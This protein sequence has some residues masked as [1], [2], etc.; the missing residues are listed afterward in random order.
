MIPERVE[1]VRARLP[2]VRPFVAA[3][4]TEH[5]RDV[6]LVRVLAGGHEGWGECGALARPTYTGEYTDGA[7]AVLRDELA[8]AAVAGRDAGVVGHPMA[9][10]AL[11][12]AIDDARLRARGENLAASLGATRERVP[13]GVVAGVAD[14]V[15]ALL[16]EVAGLVA[17]GYVRVKLKVRPGWDVEP[18]AAVR[19][20]WPELALAVDANG[21]Y[22]GRADDVAALERFGLEYVEQPLAADDLVGSAALADR[23]G[24]PIALDESVTSAGLAAAALR[25]GAC[26]VVSIKAAR[27]GG[28]D[29]AVA[30]HDAVRDAGARAFVGGMVETGVGKAAALAVAALPA[31]GLAGDVAAS[32]RWFDDDL[33]EPFEVAPDGTMAVPSG[34]GLGVAPR[35]ERLEAAAVDR[36]SIER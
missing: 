5:E 31:C 25:L 27:V 17:T 11:R 18:A 14:S 35:P 15:D 24:V 34:P 30:V 28:V 36:W 10:G 21:S 8:P 12:N 26:S 29:E 32:S 19:S 1:L 33:T 13:C 2:L 3:H 4:G 23:V 22:A 6:V 20:A 9:T 7:W 16:E